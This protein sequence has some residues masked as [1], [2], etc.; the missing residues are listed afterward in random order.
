M[1]LLLH[2]CC[3]NCSLLPLQHFLLKG[4]D[5]KG[6]W[7]NPNIHPYTEYSARLD[8]VNQLRKAWG[9]DMEC[10]D[11]Y[12]LERY[13]RAVVGREDERCG[14]CYTMRLDEAARAARKMGYGAFTT[15]LLASPYQKFGIIKDI[16]MDIGKRHGVEF[17]AEDLREGWH[18]SRNLSKELGL[19][20]QK[21][22][23]CIYS[24]KERYLK[25][26]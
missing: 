6:F 23:G 10:E 25:G 24:E 8:A 12:G 13:L 16:G 3:A 2:I 4:M 9:F 22:C 18:S 15:T 7:F 5:I 17:I 26:R 20:R 11:D 14:I 21:Y 19:Y 1:K